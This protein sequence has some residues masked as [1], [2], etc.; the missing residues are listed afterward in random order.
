MIEQ[1]ANA[2]RQGASVNPHLFVLVE[3]IA[4][5]FAATALV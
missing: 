2:I 4:F 1:S 5:V 3:R